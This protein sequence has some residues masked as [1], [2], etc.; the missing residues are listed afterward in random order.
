MKLYP[1]ID[2]HCHLDLIIE[3]GIHEDTI[4]AGMQE[5]NITGL[6]Q[7]G[8]N[9]NSFAFVQEYAKKQLP[10]DYKYTLGLHPNEVANSNHLLCL[11]HIE[12]SQNDDKF[13]A[14]GEIGLDYYYT[15]EHRAKQISVLEQFLLKAH[16]INKPV[17][18]HT[19]DAHEDTIDILSNCDPQQK[20]IIHC[21]TGGPKEIEDYLKLGCQIS[22]SG[23]VTFKN[24]KDNQEAARICPVES[25]LIET[26]APFLAPIPFR[27]KT[28]QPG[29]I[30]NTL[31][32]IADLKNLHADELAPIIYN[33]TQNIFN[34]LFAD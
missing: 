11:E 31:N 25:I 9:E 8:I 19:R 28:N 32:Y 30:R 16:K 22:F 24:A 5:N 20:I 6:V 33:N 18:I 4:F 14:I 13:V 17:C 12:N 2:T 26:D 27:G 34:H 29:Y 7:I 3:K 10:F 15:Q 23:I 1:I 21:F